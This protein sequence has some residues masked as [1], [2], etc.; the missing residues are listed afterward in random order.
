MRIKQSRTTKRLNV[1]VELFNKCNNPPRVEGDN[2]DDWQIEMSPEG[3]AK[4]LEV[5]DSIADAVEEVSDDVGNFLRGL[6]YSPAPAYRPRTDGNLHIKS[7]RWK[8]HLRM[9]ESER[10]EEYRK[11]G[12]DIPERSPILRDWLT[13]SNEWRKYNEFA[14]TTA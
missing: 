11:A 7:Q 12:L 13:P 6:I 10:N 9:C 3:V 2:P 14:G 8:S 5:L 1:R 4:F